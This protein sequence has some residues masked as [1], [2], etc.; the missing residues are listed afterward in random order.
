MTYEALWVLDLHLANLIYP[1][2][3]QPQKILAYMRK[4]HLEAAA[5]G[6]HSLLDLKHIWDDSVDLGPAFDLAY[7][8]S[9]NGMNIGPQVTEGDSWWLQA[10]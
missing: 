3:P 7:V 10:S 5:R 9:V 2:S 1:L 4:C 8:L 6:I